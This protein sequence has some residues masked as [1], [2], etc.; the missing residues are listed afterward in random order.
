MCS[1]SGLFIAEGTSDMPLADIVEALFIDRGFDV[2]LSKPDFSFLRKVPRDVTSRVTAGLE[3]M[4]ETPDLV[5]VHRDSDNAGHGVRRTEIESAVQNI[6]EKT[7]LIPI[8]PV[9]MTEAWL[10]LDESAIRQVA[11]NPRGRQ[12][13]GLPKAGEVEKIADPKTMLAECLLKA[14]DLTGRRRDR[15]DKRFPQHRRQLL[16]RLDPTGLVTTLPSWRRMIDD[17]DRVCREWT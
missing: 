2:R 17:I 12:A 5:V 16:E 13:L 9:R 4:E 6:V 8:I 7:S 11:G 15:A 1:Y 14:G 10:L 3:L